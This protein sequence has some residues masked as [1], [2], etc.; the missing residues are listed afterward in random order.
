[1]SPSGL[2][3]TSASLMGAM[4]TSIASLLKERSPSPAKLVPHASEM[5]LIGMDAFSD[6]YVPE[7]EAPEEEAPLDEALDGDPFFEEDPLTSPGAAT[8]GLTSGSAG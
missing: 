6:E 3:S 8:L 1:M 2:I 7:E 4:S 5:L